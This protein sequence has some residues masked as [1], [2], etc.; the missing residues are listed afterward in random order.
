MTSVELFIFAL[1]N[2]S[3][4]YSTMNTSHPSITKQK[5]YLQLRTLIFIWPF[6]SF[7]SSINVVSFV[8]ETRVWCKYSISILVY[9]M[10]LF[11]TTG[12][13]LSF[14]IPRWYHRPSC[15]HFFIDMNYHWYCLNHVSTVFKTLH[16][17]NTQKKITVAPFA[18]LLWSLVLN[19]LHLVPY[20][21]F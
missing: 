9:T 14:F 5:G 10:R 6:N 20:L 2:K 19:A 7:E 17:L 3:T 8:D 18:N 21:A 12:L 4:C 11:T 13:C 15:Q 1:I 16:L